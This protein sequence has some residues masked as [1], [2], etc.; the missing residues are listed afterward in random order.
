MQ[1]GS[2]K[3]NLV[4]KAKHVYVEEPSDDEEE[5]DDEECGEMLTQ[6][7]EPHVMKCHSS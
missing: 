2:S 7:N 6:M 4:L 1:G 3:S 5:E